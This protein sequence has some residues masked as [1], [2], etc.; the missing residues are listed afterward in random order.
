MM[1]WGTVANAVKQH[2]TLEGKMTRS[3]CIKPQNRLY[4]YCK[5]ILFIQTSIQTV[6]FTIFTQRMSGNVVILQTCVT[7]T[8]N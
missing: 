8:F 7:K 3:L 6:F 1:S 2:L 4:N 5:N